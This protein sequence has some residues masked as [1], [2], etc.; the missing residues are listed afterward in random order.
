MQPYV[1]KCRLHFLGSNSHICLLLYMHSFL[2]LLLVN[3][4]EVKQ[5]SSL[6]NPDNFLTVNTSTVLP[7]CK[8]FCRTCESPQN[9]L[10]AGPLAARAG[11]ESHSL[12][13]S[14]PMSPKS[15][16]I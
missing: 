14:R 10:R 16:A 8:V 15:D 11:P 5:I 3:N 2:K 6:K 9:Q 13:C 1:L 4:S 12:V 7:T